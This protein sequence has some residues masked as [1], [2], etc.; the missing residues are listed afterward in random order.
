[1]FLINNQILKTLFFINIIL[2]FSV[3]L[4]S[5]KFVCPRKEV[6]CKGLCGRFT[7]RNNDEYCDYSIFSKETIDILTAKNDTLN[8]SENNSDINKNFNVKE[9]NS[10]TVK[11]K[12][13]TSNQDNA[14]SYLKK[15]EK[16]EENE[17]T[18][19]ISDIN[20]LVTDTTNNKNNSLNNTLQSDNTKLKQPYPFLIILCS[21]TLLYLLS[22]FLVSKSILSKCTQRRIWNRLLL[23][24]FLISGLS[25]LLMVAM[26]NYNFWINSFMPLL[27]WHVIFGIA[28]A[29]ISVFHVLWHLKYYKQILFLKK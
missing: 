10:E 14:I 11:V 4:F 20:N 9:E 12:T 1:M 16:K 21:L 13:Q 24:N 8:L 29:V 19:E 15:E 25:G 7:D 18:T 27:K 17:F 5:Q 2:I 28:M 23:I 6:D 22:I 3:E 26:L